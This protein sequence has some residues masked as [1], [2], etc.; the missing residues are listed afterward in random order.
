M[1]FALVNARVS[2]TGLAVSDL[3]APLP[4]GIALGLFLGKQIG[5]LSFSWLGVRAGLCRLPHGVSW[6]KVYGVACLTGVG[7][8]MSLFVG[9]LAFDGPDQLNAVRLGVLMGSILSA[10]VGFLVLRRSLK[11]PAEP[12]LRPV[13]AA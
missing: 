6:A 10:V 9:T 5:V 2:P 4:L 12:A 13:A 3:L 1:I 8:T 11:A 7:F